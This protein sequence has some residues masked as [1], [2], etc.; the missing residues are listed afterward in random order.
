MCCYFNIVLQCKRK[1][2]RNTIELEGVFE[3]SNGTVLYMYN[4][5]QE[6]SVNFPY[7]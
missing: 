7:A 2:G 5:T 3:L 1:K 6:F 4:I